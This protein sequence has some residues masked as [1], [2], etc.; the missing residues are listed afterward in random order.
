LLLTVEEA[1]ATIGIGRSLMYELIA[2]GDIQTV[3]VGRLRRISPE[4]LREYV[5]QLSA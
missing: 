1:A 4:A 5:A 3:R 2:T